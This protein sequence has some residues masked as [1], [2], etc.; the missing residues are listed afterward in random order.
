[1]PGALLAHVDFGLEVDGMRQ[2]AAALLVVGDDL[3]HVVGHEI[4]VLHGEHRQLEA[5]HAADFAR[6]QP[7]AIHHMLGVDGAAAR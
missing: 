1:M 6:P 4:H 5:D 3:R 2:L 7:A